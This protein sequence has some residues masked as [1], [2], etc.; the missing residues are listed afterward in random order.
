MINYSAATP[1]EA[2]LAHEA[3]RPSPSLSLN[4][5]YLRRFMSMSSVSP[6]CINIGALAE[7]GLSAARQNI[8][9]T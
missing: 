2:V 3:P 6:A 5:G 9:T 1:D 8:T 4:I 7:P